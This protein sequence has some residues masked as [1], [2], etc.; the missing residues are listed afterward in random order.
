MLSYSH[1]T[2]FDR[3]FLQQ[4]LEKNIRL[5]KSPETWAAAFLPL[6]ENCEGILF[7]KVVI[8][9]ATLLKK[10]QRDVL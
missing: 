10:P 8:P 2:Q 7:I 9:V 1:F 5:E 6:A 3:E 4:L